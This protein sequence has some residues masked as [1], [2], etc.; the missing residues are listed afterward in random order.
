M[1]PK[2]QQLKKNNDKLRI[3]ILTPFDDHIDLGSKRLKY[4]FYLGS[5]T[6]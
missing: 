5:L 3:R 2:L 4:F 1:F 6:N